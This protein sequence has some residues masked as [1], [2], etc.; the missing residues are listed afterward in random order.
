MTALLRLEGVGVTYRSAELPALV[1]ASFEV[2]SGEVVLV[3]GPSGC[4]KSTL[5]QCSTVSC[6]ARTG[7]R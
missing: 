2:S 3:A 1:E 4:G 6:P 7:R 5:L